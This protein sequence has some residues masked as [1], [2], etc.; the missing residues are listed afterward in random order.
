MTMKIYCKANKAKQTYFLTDGKRDYQLF[1]TSYRKSNKAF[2]AN[3]RYIQEVLD[4]RRHKSETVRRISV[5]LIS[6]V[7]Y[8]ESEYGICVLQQTAK[9][10]QGK[11]RSTKLLKKSE[12]A[13]YE[14]LAG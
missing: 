11:I 9:K 5:R 7:K 12:R 10:R 2:F 6:T 14:L 4:A 3:G 8:I 13:D 1:T